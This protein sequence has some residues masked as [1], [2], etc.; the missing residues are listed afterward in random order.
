MHCD[1]TEPQNSDSPHTL[2]GDLQP[3]MK[4]KE[5]SMDL[6]L[7]TLVQKMYQHKKR[8]R[9]RILYV[10]Y[11][12]SGGLKALKCMCTNLLKVSAC[13]CSFL[14]HSHCGDSITSSSAMSISLCWI[15]YFILCMLKSISLL[16]FLDGQHMYVH[17]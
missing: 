16:L 15:T 4:N 5:F 14:C 7:L 9:T 2:S 10:Y 13:H 6:L 3:K 17:T 1:G 11:S 8:I 12:Y